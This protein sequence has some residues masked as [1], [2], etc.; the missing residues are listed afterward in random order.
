MINWF[1]WFIAGVSTTAFI[2][3]WFVTVDR[4]LEKSKESVDNSLRQIKLHL[5]GASQVG[6]GQHKA[7]ALNSLSVSR[8]IYQEAVKNY[9]ALRCKLVNRLPAFILGYRSIPKESVKKGEN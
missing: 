1:A 2:L 9:E 7:A 6:E 3:I 4:E 8:D 5:E